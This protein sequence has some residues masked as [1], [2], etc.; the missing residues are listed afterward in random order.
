MILFDKG[1]IVE[2]NNLKYAYIVLN[3]GMNQTPLFYYNILFIFAI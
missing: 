1:F 2:P 3:V